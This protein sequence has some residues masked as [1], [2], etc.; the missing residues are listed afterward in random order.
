MDLRTTMQESSYFSRKEKVTEDVYED[1][2]VE[3]ASG[4]KFNFKDTCSFQPE[5]LTSLVDRLTAAGMPLSLLRQSEIV[6]DRRGVFS[7]KLFE[8]AHV[9]NQYP[10]EMVTSVRV[11]DMRE[12]PSMSDFDS[13]LGLGSCINLENYQLFLH[14]WNV[15][16]EEK[17]GEEMSLRQ[18]TSFYNQ[19]DT[20][21][22]AEVHGSF[23]RLVKAQY[24]VSSDW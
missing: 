22:L 24:E 8:L 7:E 19:L 17:Y 5:R 4:V 3:G 14:T 6:L 11:L 13:S 2:D 18:Y 12:P 15:L 23:T 1:W 20:V 21:L 10:Y 16:K 9:K